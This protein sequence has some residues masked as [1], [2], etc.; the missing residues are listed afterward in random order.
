V[1]FESNMSFNRHRKKV[2]KRRKDREKI[3]GALA[4]KEWGCNRRQLQTVY[5]AM[6]ETNAY[7]A[8]GWF[9]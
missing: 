8:S 7:A 1:T 2:V 9:P 3:L 6:V 4:G 5:R